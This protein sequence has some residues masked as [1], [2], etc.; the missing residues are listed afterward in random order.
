MSIYY[1]T[2]IARSQVDLGEG[3]LW[4]E[5]TQ[6]LIYLDV[7]KNA[8]VRYSP[9]NGEIVK[10]LFPSLVSYI[11]KRKSGGFVVALGDRLAYLDSLFR[12]E[13]EFSLAINHKDVRTNDGNI[14]HLGQIW[15]GFADKIEG[16]RKGSLHKIEKNLSSSI[17]RSEIAI[18]N[19]IDWSLNNE[20]M[21]HIDSP[22]KRIDRFNFD[23]RT[24]TILNKLS[25]IDVSQINGVPDGMCTDSS[26]NI[27]VAFWGNGEVRNYTPEGQLLNI[28]KVPTALTTCCAFGGKNLN[29]LYITSANCS[30][31][32]K[33]AF[34][35]EHQG[36]LFE[37]QLP[38]VG[39]LANFQLN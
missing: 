7:F 12:I 19:G 10:H 27:W 38:F 18:S 30:Y 33:F 28:V 13:K 22:S 1:A 3:A 17:Q 34:G 37:V 4:D 8:I 29:T 23:P 20:I 15:I 26:G 35:E 14:D 9:T 2:P 32:S 31:D 36:M 24:G 39:R 5:R 25:P 21:F 6:T 16:A 11:G